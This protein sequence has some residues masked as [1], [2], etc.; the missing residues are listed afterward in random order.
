MKYSKATN[1][2]LHA[3]AYMIKYNNDNNMGLQTLAKHFDISPSYLSK[4]LTQLVKA[5][6][7]QSTPG[8]KG[9]YALRKKADQIS[10][11]DVIKATEGNE[12]LFTAELHE[13][14][15]CQIFKVMKEAENIMISYLENKK[16][17][18]VMFNN[19]N[20]GM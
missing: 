2:A 8:V 11:M 1:Y 5:G 16:I 4:I 10:F 18:E 13:D 9:G 12:E 3:I 20:K 17:Y 19:Q 7:I 6:L 15:G 14:N